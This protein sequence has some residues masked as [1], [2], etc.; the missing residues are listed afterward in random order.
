MK[1]L[2]E[3]SQVAEKQN[4]INK[5]ISRN[6]YYLDHMEDFEEKIHQKLTSKSQ[7][8]KTAKF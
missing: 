4:K 1:D 6:D 3:L 8:E 5:N 7:M 2:V